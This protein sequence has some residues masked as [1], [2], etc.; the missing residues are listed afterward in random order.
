MGQLDVT[1]RLGFVIHKDDKTIYIF[2]DSEYLK[3]YTK[4]YLWHVPEKRKK[5]RNEFKRR[6]RRSG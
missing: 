3:D 5:V 2:G 6:I 1:G 4:D